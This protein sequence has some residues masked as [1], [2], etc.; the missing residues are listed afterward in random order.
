MAGKDIRCI[1]IKGRILF[2]LKVLERFCI[3]LIAPCTQEF[4]VVPNE[5]QSQNSDSTC[6]RVDISETLV[7]PTTAYALTTE[8]KLPNLDNKRAQLVADI[9]Q[10]DEMKLILNKD[11]SIERLDDDQKD[12]VVI[13][14]NLYNIDKENLNRLKSLQ[15]NYDELMTCYEA[16]RHEN[17]NLE[18][19]CSN[20]DEME[21]EY[22]GLK[23]R[24]HEYNSLWNEK[25]HFRK[26]S[27][28]L[29]SLK[30]QYLVLSAETSSLETQL[31]A[32]SEINNI[33]CKTMD[34]LRSETISL[35]KK[36]NDASITH[37]KEKNA[38]M[39][40]LK[41]AD[42][43]IMCQE[44]QIKTLLQQIDELIDQDQG[45]V[46]VYFNTMSIDRQRLPEASAALLRNTKIH[47][48]VVSTVFH[49]VIYIVEQ[50]KNI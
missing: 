24:M 35:T 45:R 14:D 49:C 4:F 28:D 44:Q 32:E 12:E 23:E 43:R 50:A 9:I 48:I 46:R 39:C 26:R 30:E 1:D 16:L 6:Y 15:E 42:C 41:E 22:E 8:S 25:E 3:A 11:R 33:K 13:V 5:V 17:K 27:A 7:Q 40:K 18:K 19:R 10:N 21:R 34:S 36:L 29:D 31:K 38:L 37:E 2:K 20:Y 47:S